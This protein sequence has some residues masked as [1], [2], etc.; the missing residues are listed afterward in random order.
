MLRAGTPSALVLLTALAT[1]TSISIAIYVPAMPALAADLAAP[2]AMVQLTV[3][4]FLVGIGLGQLLYGPASDRF[5]RRRPLL[6][7]LVVYGLGSAA[8]A[9]APS[10]ELLLVGR[11]FQAAGA[12]AGMSLV[13]AIVRDTYPRER[14]ASALS[15][16]TGATAISPALAPILG[17]QIFL[18]FGWRADFLFLAGFAVLLLL[19]APTMLPETNRNRDPTA[20]AP[21]RLARNYGGLLANRIFLGHMVAG[22][23]ALAGIFAYT[24][25]APFI[26]VERLGVRP[27][28]F[29]YLMI[30]TTTAYV[31]GTML[32]P[33]LAR[34][35]GLERALRCG[36]AICLAGGLAMAVVAA[37]GAVSVAGVVGVMTFYMIGMG[38]AL[39]LSM[40]GAIGPF[41][42]MAG[43]ASALVGAGQMVGSAVA[44]AASASVAGWGVAGLALVLV[45]TGVTAVAAAL[46]LV[47]APDAGA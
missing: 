25:A 42:R 27:D 10:I 26:L 1:L 40:V 7:G 8:C 36:A 39:P 4:V 41:P 22:G 5:G 13:R 44:S 3:S 11:A 23:A 47:R 31:T 16:I 30:C 2:M 28:H 17:S 24:V 33:R 32:A 38:T 46:L 37:T 19:A 6:F 9:M 14:M 29:A 20:L 12:C 15:L 45:A 21:G 43:A 35:I 34:R 18:A